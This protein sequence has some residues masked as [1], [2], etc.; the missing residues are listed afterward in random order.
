MGSET[1]L[2]LMRSAAELLAEFRVPYE[3]QI[4]SAHRTPDRCHAYAAGAKKRGL[5]VIIAGS[6]GAAH[7][8]GVLAAL[9]PLPVI[10]VPIQST[11]LNGLDALLSTAQ[12]PGGVPVATMAVGKAGATN[13]ALLALRILALGDA[14]L[15]R[16]YQAYMRQQAERVEAASRRVA[17]DVA[18]LPGQ[19]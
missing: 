1:D 12:M 14:E 10:G 7:L 8:A 9:T 11:P 18:N 3:L 15:A 6:G 19:P 4:M 2:P 13:A 5:Q 16:R 17:L